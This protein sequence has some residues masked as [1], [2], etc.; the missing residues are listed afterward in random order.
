MENKSIYDQLGEISEKQD[1]I[2]EAVN[3]TNAKTASTDSVQRTVNQ[4]NQSWS[5][6]IV[7]YTNI[8]GLEQKKILIRIRNSH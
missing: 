2:L 5:L 6:S 7:R 1:E 4:R 8:C 3:R